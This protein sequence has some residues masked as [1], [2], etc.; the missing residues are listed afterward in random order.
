MAVVLYIIGSSREC[1]AGVVKSNNTDKR[2]D[3][4][5]KPDS[6]ISLA[7]SSESEFLKSPDWLKTQQTIR[8]LQD[9]VQFMDSVLQTCAFSDLDNYD[10]YDG[11]TLDGKYT[12]HVP[13]LDKQQFLNK[14]AKTAQT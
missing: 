14:T 11:S 10:K 1:Y 7:P 2:S 12:P 13:S 3:Q 9:K 6:K 5:T 8:D 4:A